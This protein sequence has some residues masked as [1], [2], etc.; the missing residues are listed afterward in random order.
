VGTQAPVCI[1]YPNKRIPSPPLLAYPDHNAPFTVHTDTSQDGLGAV[2]FQK[3]KGSSRVIA[4]ASRTLT[5]SERNY[6]MYS[7]ELEFLALRW[8]VKEQ[9]RDYFY[10]ASEFVV[11]TEYNPLAYVSTS[12]KVHATGLRG[13]E[14]LLT[15]FLKY[16]IDQAR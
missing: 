14:S 15:L 6:H 12:A 5:P 16:T 4:S 2:L 8:A 7:G 13:W 10:Y 9:F 11:Y 3:Q 1:G